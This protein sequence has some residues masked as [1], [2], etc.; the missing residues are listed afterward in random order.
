MGKDDYKQISMQGLEKGPGPRNHP[1]TTGH[2]VILPS[3]H[4]LFEWDLPGYY[5]EKQQH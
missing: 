4:C 1:S 5:A 3:M 2:I